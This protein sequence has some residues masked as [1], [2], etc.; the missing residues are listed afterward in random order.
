MTSMATTIGLRELR[1]H[2]SE[3]VRRAEAGERVTVTVSGRPAALLVP[4]D[5]PT[6]TRWDDVVAALE[7]A[8][9]P[10]DRDAFDETLV[11]PWQIARRGAQT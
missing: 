4:A 11:D 10:W 9:E 6:W 1:Q 3:Y 7:G 8:V 5:E 2:A